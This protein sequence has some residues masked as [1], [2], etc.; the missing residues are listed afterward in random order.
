M[1]QRVGLRIAAKRNAPAQRLRTSR[2]QLQTAVRSPQTAVRKPQSAVRSPQ[3]ADLRKR[4]SRSK[5][6]KSLRYPC[7]NGCGRAGGSQKAENAHQRYC[8]AW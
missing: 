2:P 6:E 7:R 4:T 1:K 8:K 5:T 3:S